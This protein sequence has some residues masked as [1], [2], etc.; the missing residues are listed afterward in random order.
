MQIE[1]IRTR[2]RAFADWQV[3]R[4][5]EGWQI[6]YS[7][8]FEQ[9]LTA[10]LQVDGES[11]SLRGRIDRIDYHADLKQFCVLDYKTGDTGNL[12]EKTH[13]KQGTWLD[14]QLGG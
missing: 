8:D 11:F 12:P 2:F 5:K 13:R 6:A 9:Q 7:E 14:L 4:T 1:Q 3:G 10:Q